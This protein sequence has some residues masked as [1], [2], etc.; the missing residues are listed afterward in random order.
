MESLTRYWQERLKVAD[1]LIPAI[2]QYLSLK[3]RER[4]MQLSKANTNDIVELFPGQSANPSYYIVGEWT[5][6]GMIEVCAIPQLCLGDKVPQYSLV[7]AYTPETSCRVL[8]EDEVRAA[9][10]R[11]TLTEQLGG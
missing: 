4:T 10:I 11:L 1:A 8:T 2:E 6:D 9:D 7:L 5:S 3:K